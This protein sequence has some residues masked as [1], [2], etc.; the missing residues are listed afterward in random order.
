MKPIPAGTGLYIHIPFCA[1]KCHY[2]DFACYTGLDRLTEPYVS[3]LIMEMD[4]YSGLEIAS[5]YFGGGTPSLLPPF[6]LTRLMAAVRERF[7]V[8]PLAEITFE[9]NPGTGGPDLWEAAF[10]AGVNRLSMGV[11]VMDDV[12]LKAIGRDHSIADVHRS[13]AGVRSAGFDDISIDLIFGLPGQTLEGWE[14]TVSDALKLAPR[15]YSVYGLQVEEKTV[16]GHLDLQGRLERPTE[17]T[18]R[19]MLD[20][21]DSRLE[22]AGFRRYEISSWCEPGRESAHNR[23]YWHNS[24]YVGLGTGA[25]SYFDGKRF[26]HGRSVQGYIADPTPPIPPERQ[27]LQEEMEETVFMG[28]R[29]VQEGLSK[30][31]FR[32]RFGADPRR[33][34][35]AEIDR[36][37]SNGLL[38]DAPD[39]LRLSP[40][41]IPVANEVFRAFLR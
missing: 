29:L 36:L 27:T 2:C 33:F 31:A 6:L 30:T 25:A 18:E 12:M 26:N 37:V 34:Y 20:L 23:I 19:D 22:G 39:A 32:E 40:S 13:L 35:E 4:H 28:L 11:Q 9:V 14:R 38:I 1:I 10:A 16:Y 41:A 3:A 7:A 15:H 24:P 8:Q 21:L 17:D 5:V